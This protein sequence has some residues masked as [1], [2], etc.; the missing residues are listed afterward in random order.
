MQLIGSITQ[1]MTNEAQSN[2]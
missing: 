1:V 2:R